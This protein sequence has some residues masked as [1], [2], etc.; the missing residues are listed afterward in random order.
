M[1]ALGWFHLRQA[2]KRTRTMVRETS[3]TAQKRLRRSV[4]T[5][6]YEW[7]RALGR[8]SQRMTKDINRRFRKTGSA[9]KQ[10]LRALA[11]AGRI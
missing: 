9:V 7:T 8:A 10:K 11:A 6:W 2:I 1:V 5:A 4:R 3:F